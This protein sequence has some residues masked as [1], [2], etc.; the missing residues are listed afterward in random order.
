MKNSE[1]IR[2]TSSFAC[3][4][5]LVP[6]LILC[7]SALTFVLTSCSDK[8]PSIIGEYE[9][10]NIAVT[11]G[12]SSS[13]GDYLKIKKTGTKYIIKSDSLSIEKDGKAEIF[14]NIKYDAILID[15]DYIKDELVHIDFGVKNI[16]ANYKKKYRYIISDNR[17][18]IIKLYL[19]DL[20]GKI[21]IGRYV[22]SGLL[23]S[24]LDEITLS[25][26]ASK[27][28]STL[29]MARTYNMRDFYDWNA[30]WTSDRCS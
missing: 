21:F 5:F 24:S 12:L 4:L 16:L 7:M 13:T 25:V 23:L 1:I 9:F 27:S 30:N 11:A 22:G 17:G 15:D 28:V 20:D 29:T 2:K 8:S 14:D 26:Q 6:L 19:F 18:E 10:N 3:L